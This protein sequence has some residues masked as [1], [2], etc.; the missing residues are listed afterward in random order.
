LKNSDREL[1]IIKVNKLIDNGVMVRDPQWVDIRG[2]VK[3]GKNVEIG[4]N[5]IFDGIVEL[6]DNV[7]IE[8]NCIIRESKI[9]ADTKIQPNSIIESSII[10][11]G[12]LIG[13]Y[14]RIRPETKIMKNVQ[15]GNFV[16]IK[17]SEIGT[18]C[19]INHLSYIGD[20]ILE[21]NVIIGA[22]S[23]TCNFDG[24]KSNQ[25]YIGSG[26]FIGS[27]VQLVAPI[28]V[29]SKAIIGAGSTITESVP[30]NMLSIAR[31]RQVILD[32]KQN[33]STK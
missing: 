4:M 9:S 21:D 7:I 30:N 28:K 12:C 2:K 27:G 3:T 26:A 14:A 29:G 11:R 5:V 23:I 15:I 6:K 16:E 24:K 18:G 1:S 10:G 20:A 33:I 22:G 25:T 8:S 31:G 32:N 17:S 19:K 13:P